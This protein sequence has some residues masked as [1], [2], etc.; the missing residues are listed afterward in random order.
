MRGDSDA[1]KKSRKIQYF[2]LNSLSDCVDFS[3]KEEV[4]TSSFL[5]NH[6]RAFNDGFI[7]FPI[8]SIT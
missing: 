5:F 3:K 8:L 7:S 2:Y 1:L 4:S 6:D